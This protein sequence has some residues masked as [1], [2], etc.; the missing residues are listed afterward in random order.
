MNTFFAARVGGCMLV[1][2]LW[3]LAAVM[4]GG[5][6]FAR[7]DGVAPE[8]FF[9][10]RYDTSI[11]ALRQRF[12]RESAASLQ[13]PQD[14]VMSKFEDHDIVFM[15]ESHG[16][17]HNLVFLESLLPRL[18]AAGYGLAFEPINA[19]N[20]GQVD[21]LL[22]GREFDEAIA[23]FLLLE[24]GFNYQGYHDVLRSAWKLNRDLP[25]GSPRFRIT[26]I[27]E[28]D[29]GVPRRWEDLRP[30]E[31]GSDPAV[32]ARMHE[33][34]G[35]LNDRD[36]VWTAI[37]HR[38]FISKGRKALVYAGANHTATRFLIERGSDGAVGH[39]RTTGNVVYDQIG[40]RA[41]SIVLHHGSRYRTQI[42][43]DLLGD[44]KGTA[45]GI[46]LADNVLGAVPSLMDGYLPLQARSGPEGYTLADVADGYV[47]LAPR[48]AWRVS[49][50]IEGAYDS[51]GNLHMVLEAKRIAAGDRSLGFTAEQ[52][53]AVDRKNAEHYQWLTNGDW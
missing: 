46:D 44:A 38:D 28:A 36:Q 31:K 29:M 51:P 23:N 13:S 39:R 41:F 45:F 50:P 19:R 7:Q 12:A 6:A 34:L 35:L 43:E 9:A 48:K 24:T 5:S 49:G 17:A 4:P 16:W 22:N 21:T 37:I 11:D 1:L 52:L 40:D 26:A 14:Y 10:L 25:K 18:H 53:M 27:D 20:Q 2:A 8:K 33:R 30:G 15:G 42:V 47:Y 3:G 32:R